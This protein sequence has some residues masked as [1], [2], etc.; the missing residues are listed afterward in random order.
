MAGIIKLYNQFL[1]RA[2]S[3]VGS[4]MIDVY[5]STSD[6]DGFSNNCYHVDGYH[7][8]PKIMPCIERQL[9]EPISNEIIVTKT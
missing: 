3:D 5:G 9:N 8:G 2:V 6:P 1:K 7:L 4:R